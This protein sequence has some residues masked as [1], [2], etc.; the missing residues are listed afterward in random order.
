MLK[1]GLKTTE[2]WTH[3]AVQIGNLVTALEGDLSP[4]YAVIV[5][6][7]VSGAYSISRGWAKSSAPK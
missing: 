3:V 4:R 7:I 2:F 6:A 1:P 5:A